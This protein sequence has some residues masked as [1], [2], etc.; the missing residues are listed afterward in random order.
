MLTQDE[1]LAELAERGYEIS[2]RRLVDWRQKELLPPL[3]KRGRGRGRA[4]IFVWEDPLIVEQVITVQE[5]L[6]IHERTAWLYTP[7]WC[8]GF[9]VPLERVQAHLLG[10]VERLQA[11]LTAGGTDPEEV[12]DR[13]S[14]LALDEATRPG[15]RHGRSRVPADALEFWLNLLVGDAAYAPNR[16]S[17]DRIAT[18]LRHVTGQDMAESAG[19]M[20]ARLSAAE[21]RLLRRWVRRHAA[22]PRLEAAARRA[23]ESE[24]AAVH[25]DWKALAHL[26]RTVGVIAEGEQWEELYPVWL[27]IVAVVGP[28][29][30]L[31]DL[32]MR[33]D[34]SGTVWDGFRHGVT[35]FA[36]RLETDPDLQRQ[37]R[38]NW[39]KPKGG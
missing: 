33:Q 13:L 20:T 1:V 30:S 27:R 9:D 34:G 2:P 7:L 21:L 39:Q 35:D 31:V 15:P 26:I 5:L 14:D 23:G 29:L 28:W 37:V 12:A 16:E 11:R 8:L 32:S 24:W 18:M 4:W 22:L 38:E 10:R 3:V 25:A 19:L 36:D 17:L 6:W